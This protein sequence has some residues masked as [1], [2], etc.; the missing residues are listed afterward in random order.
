MKVSGTFFDNVSTY[1][2]HVYPTE[3]LTNIIPSLHDQRIDAKIFYNAKDQIHNRWKTQPNFDPVFD[4]KTIL[5]IISSTRQITKGEALQKV[6]NQLKRDT[7]GEIITHFSNFLIAKGLEKNKKSRQNLH[8]E[9]Q[10]LP[11]YK[12]Q[13][14]RK[15]LG[16]LGNGGVNYLKAKTNFLKRL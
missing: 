1:D 3:Y 11:P 6:V 10:H 2:L 8:D 14:N 7:S 9:L 4:L 16:L 13:H 12:A 15:G 5:N